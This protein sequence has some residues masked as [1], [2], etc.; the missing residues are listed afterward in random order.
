MRR[1]DAPNLRHI[2]VSLAILAVW[3]AAAAGSTWAWEP[4]SVG[5]DPAAEA[6]GGGTA[7]FGRS[8]ALWYNPAGLATLGGAEVS[9]GYVSWFAETQAVCAY[10]GSRLHGGGWGLGVVYFDRGEVQDLD[11]GEG[12]YTDTYEDSDFSVSGGYGLTIPG[13]EWLDIGGAVT[14]TQLELLGETTSFMSYAGGIGA[15]GF[16]GSLNMG[17]SITALGDEV[18]FGSEEGPAGQ[19][20]T[21]SAGIL[22][23]APEGSLGSVDLSG[24]AQVEWLKDEDPVAGYGLEIGYGGTVFGRIGYVASEGS[25]LRYGLGVRTGQF[26]VDYSLSTNEDLESTHHVLLSYVP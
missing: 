19:P 22:L 23:R 8:A 16:D 14:W 21:V 2:I 24:S 4:W 13:A 15:R 20:T 3:S 18:K 17:A 7:S 11:I 1:E 10:G 12:V 26:T 6:M 5:V 25:G 9:A